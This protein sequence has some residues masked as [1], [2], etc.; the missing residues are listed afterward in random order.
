MIKA[1][2]KGYEQLQQANAKLLSAVK[3]TGALGAANLAGRY[4]TV[5]KRLKDDLGQ[6]IDYG[7]RAAFFQSRATQLRSRI[8]LSAIPFAGGIS[9]AAKQTQEADTDRVAP[10]FTA[11]LHDAPG[12]TNE[13]TEA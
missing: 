11:A 8:A 6:E 12:T 13:L 3:P 2:V 4:G 9:I 5:G 7:E 10:A 1:V